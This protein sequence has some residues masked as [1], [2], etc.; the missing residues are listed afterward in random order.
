MILV[1]S[2]HLNEMF[3]VHVHVP[4]L[5]FKYIFCTRLIWGGGGGAGELFTNGIRK[6]ERSR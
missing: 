5:L 4:E 3:I 1:T 6:D 2:I